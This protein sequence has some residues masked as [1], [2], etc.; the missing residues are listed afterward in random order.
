MCKQG[1]MSDSS[2]PSKAPSE[3]GLTNVLVN[4]ILPVILL[5]LCS[6]DP[7]LV[8]AAGKSP[9]FWQLGPQTALTLAVIFPIAYGIWHFV[10]VRKANLFS[11]IGIL[12]VLLTGGLTLYLW[13]PDGTVKDHANWWFG[14]KEASIPLIFALTIYLS[15]RT[16]RPLLH[17]FVY[18][19]ALFNIR[20]IEQFVE[21]HERQD[22]YLALIRKINTL[23]ASCFIL[24]SALNLALALFLFR[25]FDNH[26][27]DAQES[28]NKIVASITGW[29]FVVVL[30]PIFVFFYL[31]VRK[32]ISG[33][34]EVTGLPEDD[35]LMPR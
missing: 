10:K 22:A 18:Q 25:G 16:A 11:I 5:S 23:F 29:G 26:A 13:S 35:I 9:S 15:G 20:K 12:S 32:L 17:E 2:P 28:Y 6:K 24:S 4:I 8:R 19:D 34:I 7:A 31:M 30:A 14:A 27:I 21:K 33:L 1:A 3:N